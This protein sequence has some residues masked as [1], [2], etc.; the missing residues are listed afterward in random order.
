MKSDDILIPMSNLPEIPLID[1]GARP[2]GDL[3]EAAPER[4]DDLMKLSL[5]H[6]GRLALRQGDR[7]T[8]R[9]LRRHANP[10][11]G[12]ISDIAT[13][14]SHPGAYLLNL[15]YEWSCTS[16]VAADPR[17][18]ENSRLLRTLDWPLDGLGR[19]VI[20]SRVDADAGPY[21]NVTWPGFVG[22]LTAMA[23]GRF[24]AAIN[25]PPMRRYTSSCRFDWMVNRVGMWRKTGLP[26]VHLLRRVFDQCATYDEAKK[27][28]CETRLCLPAFISLSGVKAEDG[29]VV[30]RTEN[31]AAIRPAPVAVANHWVALDERGMDRGIDSRGRFEHMQQNQRKAG[32]NFDWVKSP[33]LNETTRL[34]V[35][36]CAANGALRVQGWENG[37]PATAAFSL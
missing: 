6:Y 7:A 36:A 8:K 9:W 19:N 14:V 31:R 32:D 3:V 10:Y 5:S 28:L 35:M 12:E 17:E 21:F 15:S 23:P 13:R 29:C 25:Q 4:F 1:L 22:V 24:C 18:K 20:V 30:E 34:A 27:A 2:V 16:G 11:A 33:I 37:Q 26:P